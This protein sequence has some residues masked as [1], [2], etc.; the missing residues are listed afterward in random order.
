MVGSMINQQKRCQ[1]SWRINAMKIFSR[2]HKRVYV[3]VFTEP[4]RRGRE[5]GFFNLRI[6]E[7]FSYS[8]CNELNF[9][10][11]TRKLLSLTSDHIPVYH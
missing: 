10:A 1:E 7:M 11:G 4:A 8:T 2:L 9:Y 3:V 5:G 6:K